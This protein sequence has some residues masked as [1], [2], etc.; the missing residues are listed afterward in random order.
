MYV[1]IQKRFSNDGLLFRPLAFATSWHQVPTSQKKPLRRSWSSSASSGPSSGVWTGNDE[2]RRGQCWWSLRR[3]GRG[4]RGS[5]RK[6]TT[7]TGFVQNIVHI[8]TSD[9]LSALSAAP[10]CLRET[11]LRCQFSRRRPPSLLC[12]E[13]YTL[14]VNVCTTSSSIGVMPNCT[15]NRIAIL[16]AAL[17]HYTSDLITNFA[18]PT[19]IR[20]GRAAF[21][22]RPWLNCQI[23]NAIFNLNKCHATKPNIE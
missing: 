18:I 3:G 19:A 17:Y 10:I 1:E 20:V 13:L 23:D 4:D 8:K 14:V 6:H 16:E 15:P 12:P 2:T 5:N 21:W 11:P 9:R 7:A 22:H